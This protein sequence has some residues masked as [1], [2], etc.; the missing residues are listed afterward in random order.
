MAIVTQNNTISPEV[1][2]LLATQGFNSTCYNSTVLITLNKIDEFYGNEI[3]LPENVRHQ[4]IRDFVQ[5]CSDSVDANVKAEKAFFYKNGLLGKISYLVTWIFAKLAFSQTDLEELQE[6]QR[7]LHYFSY[8]LE[9]SEEY[10]LS[11][12][13]CLKFLDKISH[14]KVEKKYTYSVV[15]PEEVP[16]IPDYE[17]FVLDRKRRIIHCNQLNPEGSGTFKSF[18][19]AKNLITNKIVGCAVVGS[20]DKK[21]L[22]SSLLETNLTKQFTQWSIPV[23][24]I[25]AIVKRKDENIIICKYCNKGDLKAYLEANPNLPL[26]KKIDIMSQFIS[27]VVL[28]HCHDFLHGDI[29]PGN[30]LLNEFA[31]KLEVL[32]NDF[33]ASAPFTNRATELQGSSQY[34]SPSLVQHLPTRH[35]N[36]ARIRRPNPRTKA[37]DIWA[38]GLVAFQLFYPNQQLP[39][40]A[41]VSSRLAICAPIIQGLQEGW[42]TFPEAQTEKERNLQELITKMLDLNPDNRPSSEQVKVALKAIDSMSESNVTF[43][44][45]DL[46]GS[47]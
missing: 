31:D 29:K 19:K 34:L 10:S 42:L 36:N 21:Q 47:I 32:L 12:S 25:K 16:S 40:F 23:S 35:N 38:C 4:R 46:I 14:S 7:K 45:T 3:Y 15:F 26:D 43:P 5:V 37:D 13:K 2:D 27:G 6:T 41:A 44:E 18:Y 33:D 17:I 1:K 11:I 9:L 30:I 8:A 20:H 22:E 24:K 39:M 28:M